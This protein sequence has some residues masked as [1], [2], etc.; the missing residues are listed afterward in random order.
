MRE[1]GL[2][3]VSVL[4][5]FSHVQDQ[6]YVLVNVSHDQT[7]AWSDIL[8]APVRRC[9]IADGLIEERAA[10]LEVAKS[11]IVASK[12]P[13][14]GSTMSGDFGEILVYFYQA[15]KQH[16][17]VAIGPKKWRLKQD[18]TKPAPYSDVIHFVVPTWPTPSAQDV[19][20]C[21]EVKAK[22][23]NGGSSPISAAIKDSAKDRTSRLGR[24]LVWLK[25]RALTEDLGA[26]TIAHL[27]RFIKATDYPAAKK[28]Y[29]AVAVICSSL[30]D[31]ELSEAPTESPTGY[32]VVV[33]SV[34]ELQRVYE[35]I[36]QAAREF[37]PPISPTSPTR[38]SR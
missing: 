17:N 4:S 35:A 38:D 29:Q 36:F 8:K 34:P 9:Y 27:D 20:L 22:A 32:S 12:L 14:P 6:P 1:L 18:R 33:I 21:S 24:T 19:I 3:I 30:L 11:E 2:D 15:A 13:D 26:V 25:E 16:P 23:T 7:A 37:A 28:Q 5:W 10:K 31:S